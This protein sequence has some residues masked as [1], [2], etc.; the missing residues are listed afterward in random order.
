MKT[1][2]TL[3]LIAFAGAAAAEGTYDISGSSMGKSENT[4]VPMGESKIYVDSKAT[5]L[6]P[7]NGTPL[8][9][10]EG[11]CFGYL[12]VAVGNGANGSGM[13]VWIDGD[14]DSWFGPWTVSG[15]SSEGASLGTW[16]VSGGTGKFTNANG[17][18]TFSS[19][20]NPE[21]GDS[22]LEVSGSVTLN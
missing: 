9:G 18:G 11:D 5:Y 16:H 2:T 1:L 19:M 13:C 20:T 14:G 4:Y 6:L 21:N 7:D 17:G 10:M 22:A 12:E 8:A 15:M 3:T